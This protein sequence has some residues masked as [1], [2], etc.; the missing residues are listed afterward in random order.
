VKPYIIL[1]LLVAVAYAN[2]L[3]NAFVGDDYGL[4]VKNPRI[5]LPLKEILSP[6]T[7]PLWKLAGKIEAW[8]VYYR[9]MVY[10]FFVINYKIWGL[11]PAGFHLTNIIL[12]LINLIN[13]IVLYR[14]GLLLFDSDNIT[15]PLIP[16][17][18]GRG[19]K[20]VPSPLVGEG[21]GE[22]GF[23]DKE[24][25]SLIA[26]S[27]FAVHPV[28]NEPAGR[29]ASG[30]VI[31][32]FFIIL[33]LYFFLKERQYLSWFTFFLALLSKEAAIMLPFALVILTTHRE[34]IK[35]GL[36]AIIPYII[37][38]SVYLTIRSQVTDTV[39]GD[40]IKQP[41][42][43]RILTMSV[44]T[45]DYI[46]LLIVPY[47]LSPYYPARWY[48]SIFE[49]KVLIAI[50]ILASITY[51]AFRIRK[52]KAM[53]F[54]LSFP[55]IMLAPVLW[56]VNTFPV[57]SDLVYIAERFLYVPVMTFSLFV[58]VSVLTLFKD[59]R[60]HIVVGWLLVIAIF[61]VITILSNRMW[62]DNLTL[63]SR[64]VK[65][66]PH[67]AF[68]HDSLG[69]AYYRYGRISEAIQEYKTALMLNPDDP[70]IYDN[71]ALAYEAGGHLA[72]A[73]NSFG[74]A[75]SKKGQLDKAIR[76]FQM[77]LRLNP[78]YAEAHYNLGEAYKQKGLINE[79]I[80]EFQMALKI[81]PDLIQARQNLE[82][83]QR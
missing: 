69:L 80:Q 63:F 70:H 2:S 38:V 67:H 30:E 60:K 59:K 56:R 62:R 68:A 45:F 55:F 82:L 19:T 73:Y 9:P 15:L 71:L 47:P 76:G 7:E 42:F 23:L 3:Q 44:A 41:I 72:G 53:L 39:L 20:E 35:K 11:N 81:N 48:S 29:A 12:H 31:F 25:L 13:V 14:I 64:I 46:R 51:L 1:I 28:H 75:Y 27:I 6:L 34:G 4:I 43:T 77:A 57:G 65:E 21:K 33:S 37:L 52:D 16:S 32:G 54:L 78:N 17:R 22:G 26:A 10:L 18:R 5:N 66:S 49:P 61:T 83:L 58:A 79:A 50:V 74:M 36:I 40:E 8:Q 24:L